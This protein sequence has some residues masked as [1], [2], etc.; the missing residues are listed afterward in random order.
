MRRTADADKD[1]T[2]SYCDVS[3]KYE[4]ISSIRT[5]TTVETNEET[6]Q[7]RKCL[8]QKSEF[9]YTWLEMLLYF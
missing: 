4:S 5:K 1:K 7:H 3:N 8:N 2:N 6:Y 9:G